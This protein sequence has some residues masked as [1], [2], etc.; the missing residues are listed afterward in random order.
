MIAGFEDAFP[1]LRSEGF[2]ETSPP[3][4]KYNCIAWAAGRASQWWWPYPHP[5]YYWPAGQTREV[6]L[7]AFLRAFMSLG[8][9]QCPTGEL[10]AGFEKV[11]IYAAEGKPTHAARQLGDG[12]WTSKLGKES[13]ITHTLRGLEG[14]VYGQVAGYLKRALTETLEQIE[15]EL[16]D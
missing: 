2:E 9:E 3:S 16:A 6:S 12:R 11:A 1:A 13:D 4:E 8:F 7:D 14:P 5:A 15:R 10:E